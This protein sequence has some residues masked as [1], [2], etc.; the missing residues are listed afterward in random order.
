M[1]PNQNSHQLSFSQNAPNLP[2][3]A[4]DALIAELAR[5]T[6]AAQKPPEHYQAHGRVALPGLKDSIQI[7]YQE[8]DS[9]NEGR[10]VAHTASATVEDV[11]RLSDT[12]EQAARTE[13]MMRAAAVPNPSPVQPR[14]EYSQQGPVTRPASRPPQ[15]VRPQPVGDQY[16]GQ[17]PLVRSAQVAP[18]GQYP[19]QPRQNQTPLPQRPQQTGSQPNRYQYPTTVDAAPQV[20]FGS[21]GGEAGFGPQGGTQTN[22]TYESSWRRPGSRPQEFTDETTTILGGG[23]IGD[24]LEHGAEDR[25]FIPPELRQ[26]DLARVQ[27]STRAAA[28]RQQQPPQEQ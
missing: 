4:E 14:A 8:P 27:E 6:E 16:P 28:E 9:R 12:R 3:R 18:Q 21:Q 1:N 23:V 13:Q 5:R 15:Y 7:A 25:Q 22:Q 24:V 2:Q 19:Q 17:G 26:E 20:P 10:L 11:R